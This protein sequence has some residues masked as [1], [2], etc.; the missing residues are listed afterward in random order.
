M[1]VYDSK[2]RLLAMFRLVSYHSHEGGVSIST[3][4]LHS[5]RYPGMPQGAPHPYY[6]ENPYYG[7]QQPGAPPHGMRGP[8]GE[9]NGG[10][11]NPY[12]G[13][14]MGGGN[15]PG[16]TNDPSNT[17]AAAE[18]MRQQAQVR[19]ETYLIIL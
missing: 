9:W 7:Q 6:M 13:H 1:E 2:H 10:T 17:A 5:F 14:P 12:G 16:A 3:D 4:H 11:P 19:R 8:G 15:Q 18:G